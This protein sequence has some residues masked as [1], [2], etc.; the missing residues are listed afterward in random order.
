MYSPRPIIDTIAGNMRATRNPFGIPK[1]LLNRWWK[2][3]ELPRQGEA[4]LFTG[5]MYQFAPYIEKSTEYLARFEDSKLAGYVGLARLMP[6]YLAGLGLAALTSGREKKR[7]DQ[8][9]RDMVKILRASQVD[10]AYRPE[11][12]QYSGV[13]LYDLGD[14]KAFEAQAR[15]VADKLNQAGI[16]KLITVDPHTT[17]ALREL[18]P[19]YVDRSFEVHSY[20]ELID[21][22]VSGQPQTVTL[23]DPCFYGRYTGLSS[24]PPAKLA[25]MGIEC[26]PVRNS[27]PYTRCCG[28]PAESLSPK[29][30]AQ[31][32]E[33]RLAELKDSGAPLVAMCPI[34]L[35]NLRKQG[36]QVEDLSSLISS[37]LH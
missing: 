14:Q 5:L 18:Y 11:L 10:F 13:L 29:L 3:L 20:L 30:A 15:W 16:T 31:V 19:K 24:L 37:S 34:C 4:L 36:A 22:T 21:L 7:Y 6:S 25:A 17:Y 9:L 12:D 28:G 2:G 27:G 32:G 26:A 23:H 35:G 33:R 8:V 1:F